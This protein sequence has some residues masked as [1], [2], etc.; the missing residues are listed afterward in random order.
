MHW[1]FLSSPVF[2]SSHL[3]VGNYLDSL[4]TIRKVITLLVTSHYRKGDFLLLVLML[5]CRVPHVVVA[6]PASYLLLD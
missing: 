1:I 3:R 4:R 6:V 5:T 2:I